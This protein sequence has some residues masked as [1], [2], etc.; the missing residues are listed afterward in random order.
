[1][2]K[3]SI[4][5]IQVSKEIKDGVTKL[6]SLDVSKLGSLGDYVK[7][8]RF[9]MDENWKLK[10]VKCKNKQVEKFFRNLID[11]YEANP[12]KFRVPIKDTVEM[13][14]KVAK[15]KEVKTAW[16]ETDKAQKKLGKKKKAERDKET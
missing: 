2:E 11:E 6:E 15:M 7:M 14:L 12:E 10:N 5:T 16:I 3:G 4:T 1:M 8:I 13:G 9:Y